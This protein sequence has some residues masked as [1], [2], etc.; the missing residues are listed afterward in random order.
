MKIVPGALV[1]N[2][3]PGVQVLAADID[4]GLAILSKRLDEPLVGDEVFARSHSLSVM[5]RGEKRI[6]DPDG[7]SLSVGE[8]EFVFLP[9][10]LYTI[11]DL[12]PAAGGTFDSY[13]F[14]FSDDLL[15]EFCSANYSGRRRSSDPPAAPE[16]IAVHRGLWSGT[17]DSFTQNLSAVFGGVQ[18]AKIRRHLLKH[19][20]LELLM[21]VEAGEATDDFVHRLLFLAR[22]CRRRERDLKAFMERYFDKPLSVEDY[23]ELSGRSAST[24]LRDFKRQFQ[25]TPRRWLT[26]RRIEKARELLKDGRM[27]VTDAAYEIGYENISHFIREFKKRYDVSPKQYALLQERRV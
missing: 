27:S 20:L 26:D 14:F 15:E 13:I 11:S 9:R 18:D 5:I 6:A 23:A 21:L 3:R 7:V 4:A 2:P 17:L 1:Q 10:D 24:F 16:D 8:N 22:R 19:K 25:S 12:L